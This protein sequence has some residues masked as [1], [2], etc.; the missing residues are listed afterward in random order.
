M[1]RATQELARDLIVVTSVTGGR[2]PGYFSREAPALVRDLI[3]V[4][5]VTGGRVPGYFSNR[6]GASKVTIL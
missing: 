3:V 6:G 5:S 4:T 1:E 2:V